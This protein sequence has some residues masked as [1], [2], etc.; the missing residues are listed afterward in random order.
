MRIGILQTHLITFSNSET[1]ERDFFTIRKQYLGIFYMK[2][3]GI[4]S[5]NNKQLTYSFSEQWC[6]TYTEQKL[7]K[8]TETV[9]SRD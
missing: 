3:Q 8:E 4:I 7:L 9:A 6:N 5:R 1:F 2:K